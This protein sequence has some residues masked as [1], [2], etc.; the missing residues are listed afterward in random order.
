MYIYNTQSYIAC[1]QGYGYLWK[2]CALVAAAF[3]RNETHPSKALTTA[4]SVCPSSFVH[5]RLRG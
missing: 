2:L 4:S 3:C 5:L 1:M